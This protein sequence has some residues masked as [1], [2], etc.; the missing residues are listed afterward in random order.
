MAQNI[1]PDKSI[2]IATYNIFLFSNPQI[3]TQNIFTMKEQGVDIFC[4]QEVLKAK[5][6]PFIGDILLELLGDEWNIEYNLG[7]NDKAI[8][9][10]VAILWNKQKLKKVDVKKIT[11]PTLT[12][13]SFFNKLFR[14]IVKFKDI[15][16]ENRAMYID[17]SLKSKKLR[18]TSVHIGLSAGNIKHRLKQHEY[19]WKILQRK[20]VLHEIICGDFNSLRGKTYTMEL[21]YI[22]NLYSKNFIETCSKITWTQDLHYNKFEKA[23]IN[24]FIKYGNIHYRQNLDH[25]FIKGFTP[26]ACERFNVQGSD[27]FPL[28]ATLT[29]N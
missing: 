1:L 26:S 15:K 14:S 21:Q 17:F 3:I 10:G 6:K 5:G 2:K 29:F 27:H 16:I 4:L 9:H 20:S 25:I 22:K 24:F 11:L 8:S 19:L 23:I 12:N 13:L 18:V 28:I 7:A